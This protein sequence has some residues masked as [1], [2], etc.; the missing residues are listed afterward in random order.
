MILS[1]GFCN[2][3]LQDPFVMVI[4]LANPAHVMTYLLIID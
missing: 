1:A 3:L 4:L 2:S